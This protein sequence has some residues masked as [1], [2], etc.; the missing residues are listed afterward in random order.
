[1]AFVTP[2]GDAGSMTAARLTDLIE[3]LEVEAVI[4]FPRHTTK[5]QNSRFN[6]GKSQPDTWMHRLESLNF[7]SLNR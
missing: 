7:E 5:I 6:G 2:Y 3:R 4:Q 1:M